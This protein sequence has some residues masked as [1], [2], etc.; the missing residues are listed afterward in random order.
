MRNFTHSNAIILAPVDSR[1]PL[2]YKVVQQIVRELTVGIYCFNQ[3]PFVSLEPNY[4]KST[5]CQLTPAYYDTKVGQILLNID[6]TVKALW[7]GATIPG[8]KRVRFSELWRSS[9]DLDASG[10]PQTKKDVF[11]EFLTAGLMD[12]SEDPSY[13]GIYNEHADADPTYDP[14]SPEEEKLFSQYSESVLLKLTSFL[15]SCRQ[16]ENL[17]VFE[18]TYSLANVV[19]LTEDKLELATYQR[20]QQRLELHERLVRK[21][22]ER[23][24]NMCK[25]L[26]YLKLIA[27]LVPFLVGLKKKM[28]IPDLSQMLP[29]FSDD[30]VKTERELPPLLLGPEFTCKHF[31]YKQDEYFHLHGGIEFDVGTPPLEEVSTEIKEACAALQELAADHL[32]DLRSQNVTYREHFPIS[33][34]EYG[35]KRYHVI[36]IDLETLYMQANRT[37]WWE[38]MNTVIKT[39]RVKRLPLTDIQLHEQFKK[40]F[41]YTKAIKCKSVPFGLKAAAERGLSAVFHSLCRRNSPSNLGV[42]DEHGYSLL[43]HAAARNQAHILCQLAAAGVSLDQ[44]RS[45]RFARTVRSG[46]GQSYKGAGTTALHLAAQCGS[47]EALNC[48]LALQANYKLADRRG[49]M[50]IHFAAYY[51]QVSCIQALC[52]KEPA[53]IETQTVAEYR[54]SPLLLAATSG[55]VPALD[56]LL[57]VGADWR[58]KDSEGNSA[59]H[60]AVLYFH[61]NVLRHL[62]E[63]D[64]EGLPVWGL[65]VEML[66]SEDQK[67]LDMA[68]RCMEALCVTAELYWKDIMDAGGIPALLS[69]LRSGRQ[70]LQCMAAAV[71]CHMSQRALVCEE[72]VQCGAVPVLLNL[73]DSLVP[74]LHSRCTVI[75]ADLATHSEPYQALIAQLGGVAPVVRLLNSNLQDV[76]VNVVRCVRTLCVRSPDNQSAVTQAGGI[77]PLVELLAIESE[78]LQEESCATLAEL[79]HGHRQN[80]DAICSAGAVGPLVQ[81]LRGRRLSAQVKA[82]RALEAVADHNPSTQSRFLKKSAAVH[83]LRLLKVFQVEVREQGAVSLWVL[84]GQT[85]KQKR[86]MAEHI[87]YHF[88]LEF[89]LSSSDKMQYVG[90]QA[91]MAL[92]QDSRSHQDGLCKEKGVPPLVRLLRG[93]RTTERTLLCVLRALRTLCIGVAHTSNLNSQEAI[94]DEKAIPTLVELLKYHKSLQ[95]KVLVAQTLACVALGNQELQV[96]ISNQRD[97]TYNHVLELLQA[98][99]QVICLEAGYAL[100]LFAYNNKAQ[101]ALILRTGG[102]SIAAY[103]PFLQAGSEIE[104]AKAA[105]QIIVLANVITDMD[106]VTLSARGVTV[107]VKLLQSCHPSTVTLTAQ[108]VASLA[109]T[110]AGIS[111]G[112]VTMGAVEHL[113]AHLF[114]EQEEVRIS[115]ACALGYL[116][117]NRNAHRLLLVKCRNTPLIYDLLRGHLI[118]DAKISQI[119]TAD[120]RRQ[121]QVGLPSLSLEANG[122]PP[123]PRHNKGPRCATASAVA[124]VT[125]FGKQRARSKSAPALR[126]RP[127]TGTANPRVRLAEPSP[128]SLQPDEGSRPPEQRVLLTGGST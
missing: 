101:Q 63:L 90:C 87:G 122:G 18:G 57:S 31:P 8:E 110:R 106:Q 11:A 97:F 42:L 72:L 33:T 53:L 112:I 99:D 49:W 3:L 126:H 37:Q 30:K 51:G 68:V 83:L 111:D 70:A 4:D 75:L 40:T 79:A 48:L 128:G 7:H 114:S 93:P 81:I 123:V 38:A 2:D 103:E 92:S 50:A 47:L 41:G 98:Q 13:R 19:R 27:F 86:L 1:A 28:K 85:L 29:Q 104:R 117:F 5:S 80:Q 124:G 91:V 32:N 56:F 88:I 12:I 20:L 39:L 102:V 118:E 121:K 45:T 64:L 55:S 116:S 89:L 44:A 107:L 16:H 125:E 94:A 96:A 24:A 76:L 58:M 21:C 66:H 14:S 73:L 77:P 105:F 62:I 43:H 120:F 119:F 82:A 65:L 71:V 59:A 10:I 100:A 34:R 26:A 52:R 84:G 69:L 25:S 74:E 127:R 78:V 115:C 6:Y 95:V 46:D 113:C 109:H 61:T 54:S 22:L 17:F 35:G 9:M 23:K 15:S 108:L 36:A 67:R 60:L